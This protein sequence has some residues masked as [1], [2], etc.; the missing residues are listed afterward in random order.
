MIDTLSNFQFKIESVYELPSASSF[1]LIAIAVRE[2][3][4]NE[5]AATMVGDNDDSNITSV[6]A[7]KD[8]VS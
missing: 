2:F 6:S 7:L 5:A 8:G 4:D 3:S 1:A